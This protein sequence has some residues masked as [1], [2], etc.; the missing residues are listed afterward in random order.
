MYQWVTAAEFVIAKR[1][2]PN[3]P[4]CWRCG[5][6]AAAAPSATPP[7][8]QGEH[9]PGGSPFYRWQLFH[10]ASKLRPGA[11]EERWSPELTLPDDPLQPPVRLRCHLTFFS[12]IWL[13]KAPE[14]RECVARPRGALTSRGHERRHQDAAP[15]ATCWGVNRQ[16]IKPSTWVSKSCFK[17]SH[18]A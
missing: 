13:L 8:A 11:W 16:Q 3:F 5:E 12:S 14:I 2:F 7:A 1:S 15:A 18:S 6:P 9:A 4:V 17:T 10:A